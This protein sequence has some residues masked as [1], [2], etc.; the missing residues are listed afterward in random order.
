MRYIA[1]LAFLLGLPILSQAQFRY[2]GPGDYTETYTTARHHIPWQ[3]D[4]KGVA[5]RRLDKSIRRLDNL[6]APD[7]AKSDLDSYL[8][9]DVSEWIDAGYDAALQKFTDCDGSLADRARAVDPGGYFVQVR[10]TI[11]QTSASNTGWAAGET[12]PSE[13]L[14]A[15]TCYYFSEG[16]HREQWLPGLIA[17]EEMNHLAAEIGVRG[18]PGSSNNWPCDAGSATSGQKEQH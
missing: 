15:V 10:P 16:L 7:N 8:S 13:R 17:W 1:P 4:F 5:Q 12:M 2:L 14:I 11:W 9:A 18:E 6:A 3:G